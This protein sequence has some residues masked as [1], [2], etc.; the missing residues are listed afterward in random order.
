MLTRFQGLLLSSLVLSAAGSAAH[1]QSVVFQ[2]SG[3]F[4]PGVTL[5]PES[6]GGSGFDAAGDDVTLAGTARFVTRID[7]GTRFNF[8]E[9]P[10]AYTGSVTM[11]LYTRAA[12]GQVGSVIA[13]STAPVSFSGGPGITPT[14]PTTFLFPNTPVPDTFF[15]AVAKPA[16]TNAFI[17][18]LADDSTDPTDGPQVGSST[19]DVIYRDVGASTFTVDGF[20]AGFQATITAAAAVPEPTVLAPAALAGL[21]LLARR[22][23]R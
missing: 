1:G 5:A 22:R 3:T 16:N 23:R 11:T 7:V 9:N 13:T 10:G 21:G 17:L 18:A 15:W 6:A 20:G 12:N 4:G 2:N 8:M 14:Q 19:P